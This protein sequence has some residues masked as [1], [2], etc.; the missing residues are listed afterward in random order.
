MLHEILG[1][2]KQE[3]HGGYRHVRGE[4]E[5]YKRHMGY[6]HARGEREE[7]YCGWSVVC[8]SAEEPARGGSGGGK[9][10]LF[11]AAHEG[12]DIRTQPG[13]QGKKVTIKPQ[14]EL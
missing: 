8:G 12:T 5:N 9:A 13:S 3:T 10:L 4:E 6:T 7:G 14:G 1:N 11:R 2:Q